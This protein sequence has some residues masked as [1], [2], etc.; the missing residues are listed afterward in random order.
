MPIIKSAKKRVKQSAKRQDRNYKVRG[1]VKKVIKE[2]T[3][4]VK[5][6]K[7]SDA[8]KMLPKAYKIIDTAGKKNVLNKKTSARRKSS[9]AKAVSEKKK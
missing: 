7:K 4:L 3:S 1:D 2:I 9:L 6:G 8:E 5:S